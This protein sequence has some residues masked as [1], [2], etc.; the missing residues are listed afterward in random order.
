MCIEMN[1]LKGTVKYCTIVQYSMY[2]FY[3]KLL[4]VYLLYLNLIKYKKNIT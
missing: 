1:I 2:L 3:S 4:N